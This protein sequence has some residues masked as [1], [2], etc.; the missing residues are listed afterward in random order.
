MLINIFRQ[1]STASSYSWLIFFDVKLCL[2]I[3]YSE[4]LN[5]VG[6][7][8]KFGW[9]FTFYNCVKISKNTIFRSWDGN[10]IVDICLRVL[11]SSV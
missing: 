3:V 6:Q 11:N 2:K 8:N 5:F 1:L 9:R 10:K 4:N 7:L